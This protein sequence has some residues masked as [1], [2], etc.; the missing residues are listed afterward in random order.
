DLVNIALP[1]EFAH[2]RRWLETLGAPADVSVVPG[3]HDA[4][5]A[6]ARPHRDRHWWPFMAGD[7]GLCSAPFP[8]VG[9]G[10]REGAGRVGASEQL[11]STPT[12]DPSLPGGADK[13]E[14]PYLRRRGPVA[15]IGV[16]TAIATAPFIAAGKMGEQQLACVAKTLDDLRKENAFRVV[17]IH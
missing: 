8:L 17:M 15:L 4:Y 1:A 7:G 2:A 3:N 12:L 16:S 10:A 14:F 11:G 5:V 9:E 13:V 6:A